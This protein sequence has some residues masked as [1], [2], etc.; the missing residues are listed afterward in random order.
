MGAL[1][2][3]LNFV[4]FIRTFFRAAFGRRRDKGQHK[5][6]H[7]TEWGVEEGRKCC[8][9]APGSSLYHGST[10][11]PEIYSVCRRRDRASYSRSK[12]TVI[13]KLHHNRAGFHPSAGDLNHSQY[14][15]MLRD[16][17]P[18]NTLKLNRRKAV[19]LA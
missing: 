6:Q 17:K 13:K 16:L 7:Y 15:L 12:P 11:S 5:Q 1:Q 8:C 4:E 18:R 14:F 19:G 2:I 9:C 10:T 3:I